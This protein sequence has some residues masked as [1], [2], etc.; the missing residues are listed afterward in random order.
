MAVFE[1]K[2]RTRRGEVL[3]D[4]V[5]GNDTAAVVSSLRQQGLLVIDVKEQSVGQKD[6]LEPFKRVTADDVVVF[7][8]QFATMIN[9]GLPI[10]RA[11]NILG[12][13]AANKKFEDVIGKVREDVEAGLSLSDALEKHPKV[14]NR[15]YVEMVRAGEVGGILDGVLLR[16]ADQLE[17]DQELRRKVKSAMTY[18]TVVLIMAVLAA[19]VMLI[20]IVPIFAQ[21]FEDLGG[22]LP[23]PTRIA[24]GLSDLLTGIGGLFVGALLTGGGFFFL[25]WKS[26]E[27]GRKVWDRIVL[28]IPAKIGE[29]VQKVALARFAR[30]LGTL[31]SAGVPILQALEIT[32]KSSGNYVV[33]NALL[34]SRDSIRQGIPIY[35]PLE[36]EPVFPPM[37]TRMIAVGEETGD[38]DGM[39]SKIG[40]FYE[41][42]VDATVK[43]LTSIIEPLMIVV[44][45]GIVGGIII[46][47]Y[48]PMFQIFELIE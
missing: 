38:L 7:T 39:L 44:V 19:A 17:G 33:E 36:D 45:G 35:T 23:L 29:V 46:A 9:A 2:A 14:F 34:K 11:L 48:L 32:A 28:K 10:V 16:I 43:S 40:D 31:S 4:K 8:R 21:M 13:Q 3:Q 30:T 27:Q 15:L 20:F 5:E 47:M 18:P 41:S 26:T 1:Y 22:T 12:E 6:I 24:M 25:R 37:V 42:E